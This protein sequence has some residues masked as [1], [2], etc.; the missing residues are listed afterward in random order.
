MNDDEV[1]RHPDP[2]ASRA[3]DWVDTQPAATEFSHAFVE[4]FHALARSSRL[5]VAKR[6]NGWLVA[7]NAGAGIVA[8]GGAPA[9]LMLRSS[10]HPSGLRAVSAIKAPVGYE[11]VDPF[12]RDTT[13]LRAITLLQEAFQRAASHPCPD[14]ADE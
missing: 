11:F 7:S 8:V 1:A 6:P 3:D 12:P 5:D 2:V 14:R 13:F 4:R 9:T 10:S